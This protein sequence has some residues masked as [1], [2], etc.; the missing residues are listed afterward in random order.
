MRKKLVFLVRMS[1]ALCKLVTRDTSICHRWRTLSSKTDLV[2]LSPSLAHWS[3]VPRLAVATSSPF[4]CFNHFSPFTSVHSHSC[5]LDL[6][7]PIHSPTSVFLASFD[8]YTP[9]CDPAVVL[10]TAWLK[11]CNFNFVNLAINLS[12]YY[13]SRL[14]Q[15]SCSIIC[16]I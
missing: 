11:F 7:Q 3:T 12:I 5:P 8:N 4:T 15:F 16:H 2:S 6:S 9:L 14:E 1:N 13:L 10:V